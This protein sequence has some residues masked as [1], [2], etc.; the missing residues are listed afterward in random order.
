MD[1]SHETTLVSSSAR[2]WGRSTTVLAVASLIGLGCFLYPFILPIGSQVTD[3]G[4][5]HA[6]LAPLLFAAVVGVCLVAILVTMADDGGVSRSRSV[7]LLGVLV[8]VDA[9][10]RLIPSILGASA[11]FLLIILVGVVFG[12]AMG[13][14]MGVLT[15]LFSAL[16]TGGFGPWLPFQMLGAGW[17]GLTAGWLPNRGP[18]PVRIAVIA[19]FGALWGFAFG[20]LMNLW[21]WPFAAPGVGADTG[22]YWSPDL[23]AVETAGRYLRFYAV[24]SL[25]FDLARAVGNIVLAIVFGAPILRLLERYKSRFTWQAWTELDSGNKPETAEPVASR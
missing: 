13:F 10:L 5:A 12:A 7:A 11:I 25:G 8:A 3:E 4:K 9:T 16:I 20:A 17:V 15:L 14:Q 2:A 24:T 1:P 19:A 23:G 18:M 21:F 6:S 22:L